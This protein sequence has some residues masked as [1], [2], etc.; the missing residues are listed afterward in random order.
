M[1]SARAVS[2]RTAPR[3][4]RGLAGLLALLALLTLACEG[5]EQPAPSPP[6]TTA[7]PTTSAPVSTA[8][9]TPS[10]TAAPTATASPAPTTTPTAAP[11]PTP[12]PTPPSVTVTG[13]LLV[14]SERVGTEE[15]TDDGEIEVRRIVIY[16]L[17]ADRYWTAFECRHVRP[18]VHGALR[19]GFS[20]VQPA[21]TSLIV[22]S[23]GQIRRMSLSGKLEALL[24][25]QDG[26]REI[27]VS[28]DG[29]KVAVM[30]G[31]PG[32]LLVLDAASGEELLRVEGDDPLLAPLRAHQLTVGSWHANG[33]ALSLTPGE[34]WLNTANVGLD[35]DVRVLPEGSLVSPDLRYALRFGSS[36]AGRD[37]FESAWASIEV[38][39]TETG[40]VRWTISDDEGLARLSVWWDRAPTFWLGGSK[41]VAFY[42]YSTNARLIL[43]TATGE[44]LTLRRGTERQFEDRVG[45]TCGA[46]DYD[47]DSPCDVTYD[48]RVVWDGARGWTQYHG[49]V[50]IPRD[51]ELDGVNPVDVVREL[52]PPLPPSRTEMVGP[53]LA[54]EVRGDYEY[55]SDGSG[56]FRSIPTRRVM[57]Y[58]EGTGRSWSLFNDA[59]NAQPARGGVV[60]HN[61]SFISPN[62]ELLHVMP[63]GQF[64]DLQWRAGSDDFRVSPDGSKVLIRLNRGND[65]PARTV[66]LA[67]PSGEEI[68]RLVHDDLPPALGLSLRNG[69]YYWAVQLG[70][71]CENA[72]TADSRAVLLWL[73]EAIDI[74]DYARGVMGTLDGSLRLVPCVT[75]L[76]TSNSASLSCLS[77][78]ARY[79]V[80][81][82]AEDSDEYTDRNWRSFDIIDSETD[83]VL[84]S[85]ETARPIHNDHWEWASGDHFAWSDG[86]GSVFRFDLQRPDADAERADVSV[87]D[88]TTGEIEVMDSADYLAR[89]HPPPRATTDC[90]ENPAQPCKILLDGEVVGEGRW[91]RIIGFIELD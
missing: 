70:D 21:G 66:V 11:S 74:D 31:E 37:W 72:W 8:S 14:L 83:R 64:V 61:N 39:D 48:S 59:N 7:T 12:T 33:N 1:A 82:R 20:A 24:L 78:D 29:T 68:W 73:T 45:S 57:V 86:A 27:E 53:L 84:W 36:V 34:H 47:R 77:P 10:A 71:R 41:Y 87:L 19:E 58:D 16:D 60:L 85:A 79:V 44:I 81:G 52:P 23:E 42:A 5:G 15:E 28:P 40:D 54:Y 18:R 55:L 49:L 51:L 65:G 13:P 17:G 62:S 75:D 67:L 56:G 43:D 63:D 2:N 69:A 30:L 91:P 50:E 76:Y 3:L 6:A 80:L 32:T 89:F 4:A 88:V 26:I 46:G 90:P 22:W 9:A 38:L 25:E 35:G